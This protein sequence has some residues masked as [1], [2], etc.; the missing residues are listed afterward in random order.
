MTMIAV[1]PRRLPLNP[2]LRKTYDLRGVVGR[3]LTAEDAQSLGLRF[4]G[5]AR[6]RGLHRLAVSRDG[7]LSSPELEA[8]LVEGLVAGGMSVTR[9]PLGPTPLVGFAVHRLGLDGGVMVTG[10]HNPPDQ[11]G[12]KLLL[13]GDPLHGAALAGLWQVEPEE[14]PGGRISEVDLFEIISLR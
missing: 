1:R 2:A 10:S 6:M 5:L 4:A 7:R 12:F 8:A 3:T 11:N 9:L 13:G 14:V